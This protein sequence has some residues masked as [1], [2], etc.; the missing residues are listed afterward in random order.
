AEPK[1]DAKVLNGAKSSNDAKSSNK[2]KSSADV[3]SSIKAKY[4]S[5]TADGTRRVPATLGNLVATIDLTQDVISGSWKRENGALISPN[6]T[7]CLAYLPQPPAAD[8]TLSAEVTRVAGNHAFLIGLIVE[9][10]Q[11]LGV[12]DFVNNQGAGLELIDGQGA[13]RNETHR[14]GHVING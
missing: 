13:D 12:I 3:S 5:D 2:V 10:R 4:A 1:T 8:Y 6:Q 14:R 11:V 7:Y 9:G